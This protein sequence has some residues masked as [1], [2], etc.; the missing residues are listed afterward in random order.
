MTKDTHRIIALWALRNFNLKR[1]EERSFLMGSTLADF[2]PFYAFKQH[3]PQESMEHVLTRDKRDISLFGLG[4]L[5]HLVSDFL[6][7]PHFNN[8]RLYSSD[9]VRH[10]KFEK[11]LEE[12][13]CGFSFPSFKLT[14][15]T[16]NINQE[17]KGLYEFAGEDYED[18]LRAAYYASS[19]MLENFTR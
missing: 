7:T 4:A 1:D 6:C 10:I 15:K 8:W 9:A 14:G 5:S 11:K 13:A 16:I 3:Y 12:I 2:I 17:I 19:L 18:N